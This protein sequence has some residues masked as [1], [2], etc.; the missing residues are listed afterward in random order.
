MFMRLR[1]IFKQEEGFTLVEMFKV[2]KTPQ[3][4]YIKDCGLFFYL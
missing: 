3:P 1:K 4:L 2:I